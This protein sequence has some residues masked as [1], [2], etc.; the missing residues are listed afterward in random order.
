MSPYSTPRPTCR[1]R[2]VPRRSSSSVR[3][4]RGRLRVARTGNTKTSAASADAACPASSPPRAND[5]HPHHDRV[6]APPVG[7]RRRRS[8]PTRSARRRRAHAVDGRRPPS[9]TRRRRR[10]RPPTPLSRTSSVSKH[11]SDAGFGVH[12]D[13]RHRPLPAQRHQ[14][15]EQRRRERHQLP[16]R[17]DQRDRQRHGRAGAR[18]QRQ[19]RSAPTQF[20]VGAAGLD[21][22]AP[23]VRGTGSRR[24]SSSTTSEPCTCRTH[25]SGRRLIRCAMAGTAS[26][27]TSSGIT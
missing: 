7:G 17:S 8:G 5:A 20:D 19:R 3:G 24:S 25:I 23:R 2:W 22:V 12:V 11:R 16:A 10:R 14:R 6:P 13:R 9:S 21:H 26:A 27:L 4:N 15:A 18:R 1:V